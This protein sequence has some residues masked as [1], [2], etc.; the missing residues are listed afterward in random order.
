MR[1]TWKWMKDDR[2][3]FYALLAIL[4]LVMGGTPLLFIGGAIVGRLAAQA[5]GFR[6]YEEAPNA[7]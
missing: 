4:F 1:E 3:M 2:E 7:D 6:T 5:N